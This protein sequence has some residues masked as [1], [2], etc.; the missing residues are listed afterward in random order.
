M[1]WGDGD[2]V[3]DPPGTTYDASKQTG[4]TVESMKGSS[5]SLYNYYKRLLLIRSA[6]PEIARGTYRALNLQE[7]MGGFVSSWNGS[8]VLVMH[9]TTQRAMSVDLAEIGEEGFTRVSA[10]IGQGEA[11]LQDT[12]LTLEG[13]TSVVL[14]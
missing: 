12:V 2:P 11:F 14:R 4:E 3:A 13:Q 8:S 5:Y 6:H 7:K 9:N 10:V 1:R